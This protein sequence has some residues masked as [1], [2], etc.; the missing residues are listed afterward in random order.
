[1]R[2]VAEP[3]RRIREGENGGPARRVEEEEGGGGAGSWQGARPVEAGG[4]GL[5]RTG[6]SGRKKTGEEGKPDRWGL[7]TVLAI[8]IKSNRSKTIQTNLN[9]NQT[10]SNF[11]LSKLDL[12]KLK[13]FEIKYF[14][15][16]LMRGITF[17]I[18]TYPDSRWISK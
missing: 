5:A 6:G 7:V 13:K 10:R 3:K 2:L 17:S 1:V 11:I 4:V 12:H 16:D 8:Q 18:G 14:L 15:K 9:S